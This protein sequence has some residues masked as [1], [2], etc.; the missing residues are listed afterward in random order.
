MAREVVTPTRVRIFEGGDLESAVPDL[1]RLSEASFGL[2]LE[3]GGRIPV[4]DEL[5]SGHILVLGG[6]GQGKTTAICHLLAGLRAN[7]KKDDV[8]VVFD[9]KGD[10]LRLFRREGDIVIND[11]DAGADQDAWNLLEEVRCEGFS[12]DELAHEVA[13]TLFADTVEHANQP[14]FPLT[15]QNLFAATLEHLASEGLD[16]TNNE[17]KVRMNDE[18]LV[19]KLIGSAKAVH[20]G[21]LVPTIMGSTVTTQGVLLYL[22]QVV[23]QVFAGPFGAEG[24]L[25]IR[26]AIRAK[27]ARAIFLEYD[28]A[29]GASLAPVWKVLV[30]LAIKEALSR[31][32]VGGRVFFILD[33]L[34][35]LPHLTHLDHGV[36]FGRTEG[37]SFIVSMQNIEQLRASYGDETPSILSAFRTVLAYRVHDE[38]T[39]AF[40]RNLAG[41]NRKLYT[42]PAAGAGPPVQPAVEG[43]V[44]EDHHVWDLKR[45]EAIVVMPDV[46]QPFTAKLQD[47]PPPKEGGE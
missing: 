36:N 22:S 20:R 33:E 43:H 34:R 11:P 12:S 8:I 9:P 41:R 17:L 18:D 31:R 21:I 7:A 23:N 13:S 16:L 44:I 30:D 45:A 39:R 29:R 46:D 26:A 47:Y 25:S 42:L 14:V 4:S 2:P 24:H 6:I 3:S 38:E 37:A 40:V 27:K 5:L 15:A 1:S 28:V 32:R 10:F 19:D 35:L